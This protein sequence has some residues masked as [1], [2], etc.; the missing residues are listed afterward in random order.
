MT[1]HVLG[2]MNATL[3]PVEIVHRRDHPFTRKPST[4]HVCYRCGEHRLHP[5]HGAFSYRAF[6]SGSNRFVYQKTKKAWE[7]MFLDLLGETDLP[8]PCAHIEVLAQIC[9][10]ERSTRDEDNHRFVYSKFLGDALQRGGYLR[11][12]DWTSFRFREMDRVEPQPG[13][14]WTRLLLMPEYDEE[15]VA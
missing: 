15:S 10:P 8:R 12:D 3:A 11:N 1:V 14:Q 7:Q 6:G 4:K 9:F 2:S 13:Q 5:T